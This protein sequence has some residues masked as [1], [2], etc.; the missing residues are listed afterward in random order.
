M[1]FVISHNVPSIRARFALAHDAIVRNEEQMIER[2]AAE[3]AITAKTL[4]PKFQS[5]LVNSILS[6]RIGEMHFVVSQG[7]N[8]GRA[9]EEGTGPAV[10]RPK[11]YPNV[12]NLYAVL[13]ASPSSRRF[14]WA[15]KSSPKREGQRLE[16]WFRARAWAWFI[17]QHGTK[18][19][20]HMRPAL[21]QNRS[22]LMGLVS[23]G[24]ANGIREMFA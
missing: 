20:P 23:E 24:A 16:L 12:D 2:G 11:Y 10:G 6:E 17:Y 22:V 14:A 5:G 15:A 18:A 4:A 7:V 21:E 1:R 8:Y 19:Q 9:V 3:V 13:Q